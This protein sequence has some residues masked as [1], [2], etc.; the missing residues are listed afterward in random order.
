MK[1]KEKSI[2][3]GHRERLTNLIYRSKIENVSNV[4]AVEYFLTYI[5][6]R[7]DVN[8]LAHALLDRYGTFA[9]ILDAELADLKKVKGINERSAMKI[10]LFKEVMHLYS[11]SK[12]S[13]KTSLKNTKEFVNHLSKLLRFKKTENLMMFA[14]DNN[15]NLIETRTMNM[16]QVR[17]VGIDPVEVFNFIFSTKASQFAIAHNHPGGT[18]RPSPDDKDAAAYVQM[19]LINFECSYVDSYIVGEDGIY[20]LKNDGFIAKYKS[21]DSI[22]FDFSDESEVK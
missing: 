6:P 12:L 19:L 8:P 7:G 5:F 21:K 17:S 4:Q 10:S 11:L 16:N 18:A 2:H 13:K 9:N 22:L 14:I 1:A 15:A 3:D 20:S